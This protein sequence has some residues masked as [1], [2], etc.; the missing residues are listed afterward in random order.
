MLTY[1][2]I[3][4]NYHLLGKIRTEKKRYKNIAMVVA[5]IT[6]NKYL[7]KAALID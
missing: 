4:R 7:E 6:C 5:T 3:N 2:N 1:R